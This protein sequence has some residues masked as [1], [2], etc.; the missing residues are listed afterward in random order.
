M[1][2]LPLLLLL[3]LLLPLLVSPCYVHWCLV[4]RPSK[5]RKFPPLLLLLS[6]ALASVVLAT[7]AAA[8]DCLTLLDALVTCSSLLQTQIP[9]K[10]GGLQGGHSRCGRGECRTA[11]Q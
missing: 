11:R 3:L 10:S 8:V 1:L 2:L 7:A 4:A 5:L 9:T 6:S